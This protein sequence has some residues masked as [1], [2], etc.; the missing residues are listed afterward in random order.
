MKKLKIVILGDGRIGRAAEFFLKKYIC[1]AE[2]SFLK[3]DSHAQNC[4]L[5]I[6]ALPGELGEKCLKLA[7]RYK[8]NLVDISDVDP[9][10][11]LRHKGQI[12]KSGIAVIPE[13]GFSPGLV[14][15]LI[16]RELSVLK[17]FDASTAPNP[18]LKGRVQALLSI[19]PE[20]SGHYPGQTPAF[21]RKS[22]RIDSI[23]VKAGSLSKKKNYF[24]F[25]WCFEDLI[26]EHKIPSW[27]LLGGK[28]KK[29][30]PFSG[31]REER[32]SGIDAETYLC[33]SGFEHL[34]SLSKARD[35]TCRV[36]RPRGFKDF[37][38]FLNNH[39]FLNK[40]SFAATKCMLEAAAENNF[41]LGEITITSRGLGVTWQ[42]SSFSRKGEALNSMQKITASAPAVISK[43]LL[44]GRIP[45][46]GLF[47]M[48]DLGKEKSNFNSLLSEIKKFGVSLKRSM[49]R[50]EDD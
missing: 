18:A 14:N 25:L 39:G 13:C 19:N 32:F 40:E 36:I 11:Y 43:W 27:Q 24:P 41:T 9:P 12:E 30:P 44:E 37:F 49:A 21:R 16:G 45:R 48:E 31:L 17:R 10:F 50:L 23:E 1:G 4:E 34:L 47:F 20:R 3:R 15:F 33:A 42:L 8:K 22:R 2:V 35:F 7:L 29:F 38:R 5:L 46:P 26:L 6:G 28:K